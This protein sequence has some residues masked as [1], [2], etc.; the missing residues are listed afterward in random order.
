MQKREINLTA[1]ATWRTLVRCAYGVPLFAAALSTAQAQGTPSIPSAGGVFERYQRALQLLGLADPG[2]MTLRSGDRLTD[3]LTTAETQHPWQPT[4]TRRGAIRDESVA[5]GVLWNSSFPYGFNDGPVWAGKGAT[6]VGSAGA[7]ARKGILTAQIRPVG[8]LAMND[9]FGLAVPSRSDASAFAD[10]VGP[11]W[12][13]Q[14]QRFG[15]DRYGR[16]DPGESFVRVDALG[17]SAGLSSA[18]EV[19]GPAYE[20]PV[21]LGTN[22]GGFPRVF[23]GTSGPTRVGP[24]AF[25]GRVFWGRLE[26]SSFRSVLVEARPHFATGMV[27]VMTV[28]GLPGLELGGSRFYHI[29]WPPGGV[30][31]LPWTRVFDLLFNR[32]RSLPNDST[33]AGNEDNQIASL[34]L[35]VAPPGAGFEVYGEFGRDDRNSEWV[36]LAQEPDHDAAYLLGFA[37]AWRSRA[38][39][40]LTVVRGEVLNSRISHLQQGRP[41]APFYTHSGANSHGHTQRGQVLGSVGAYGGGAS[42]LAVDRYYPGGRR[43]FRWDRIVRRTRLNE[44][45]LP[46]RGGADVTHAIGIERSRF[47]SASEWTTSLTIVKEFN[48]NFRSDAVNASIGVTYRFLR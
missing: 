4:R 13:D 24:V 26:E 33:F 25:H 6:L 14:P 19:W 3:S 8:F 15:P 38:N 34:F 43:T 5:L 27:G 20:H 16:I 32:T 12:I 2:L 31:D 1:K 41:Q 37:R 21:V 23:A 47:T 30:R 46:V 18:S 7:S 36:D 29:G 44:Y 10:F 39:E 11:D 28:R 48:Q 42:S 45:G 9:P 17:L 22:A 35:R 40:R